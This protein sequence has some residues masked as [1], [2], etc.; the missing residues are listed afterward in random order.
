[1]QRKTPEKKKKK[2]KRKKSRESKRKRRVN[3]KRRE[4][5]NQRVKK[6]MTPS[7]SFIFRVT[8]IVHVIGKTKGFDQFVFL[9]FGVPISFS[10]LLLLSLHLF[11]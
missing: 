11:N 10:Y 3:E 6:K 7:M 5:M 8:A 9:F 4:K 1:L 2:G